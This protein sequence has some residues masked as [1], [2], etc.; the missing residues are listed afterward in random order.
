MR[1]AAWDL[2]D[3]VMAIAN[4]V[5]I[6]YTYS[7]P[8]LALNPPPQLPKENWYQNLIVGF[9]SGG[10]GSGAI[11]LTESFKIWDLPI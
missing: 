8:S 5:H 1:F 6:K 3:W 11:I 7:T 2:I 9:F 4:Y 10:G